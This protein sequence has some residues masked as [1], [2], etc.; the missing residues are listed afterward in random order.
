MSRT[1]TTPA[2]SRQATILSVWQTSTFGLHQI[3]TT[4][5]IRMLVKISSPLNPPLPL[6]SRSGWTPHNIHPPNASN[7]LRIVAPI[8]EC[9]LSLG[10][11]AIRERKIEDGAQC[12]Y[13]QG[14]E[15]KSPPKGALCIKRNIRIRPLNACPSERRT[16][17]YL[18]ICPKN[19]TET[20][21]P[22]TTIG[23]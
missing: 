9:V 23:Y 22:V 15:G 18:S 4:H 21:H 10:D 2:S 6:R 12:S 8:A 19:K 16:L 20:L 17:S 3:T 13:A 5:M 1:Q 14:K 7:T 11:L